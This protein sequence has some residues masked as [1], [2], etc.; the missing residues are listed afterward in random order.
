MEVEQPHVSKESAATESGQAYI[1]RKKVISGRGISESGFVHGTIITKK[2]W[3]EME[4]EQQAIKSRE[5]VIT[6]EEFMQKVSFEVESVI[7]SQRESS[8]KE[9]E[10]SSVTTY[11]VSDR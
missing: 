1:P 3:E 4:R 5:R 2:A 9:T 10:V 6:H 8:R 11:L 7:K